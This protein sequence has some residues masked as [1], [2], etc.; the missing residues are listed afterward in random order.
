MPLD[1]YIT[2]GRSG[3]R[4]S[5]L[6]LGAMTFGEEWGWGST[7]ED[8]A[9]ILDAYF[10][11]GGNFIDT[12]NAYTKGHSE[13]IIG[14]H[15]GKNPAKRDRAVIA[16]KFY[17]NLY[18]GD[19][20][21]GGANRKSI[22]GACEQS[23]RCLQTDYIDLY[24]MHAWD[25]NTPIVETM[26][27]LDDLVSSGKVRYVGFSDIPAW[28]CA[29][30]QTTATLRGWNTLVAL[31][32]EYSLL[33]RSVEGELVPMA[34]EMGLG[35]TP[36][37]PLKGGALSGKFKRDGK[38]KAGRGER[39]TAVLNE[40]TFALLD[41]MESISKELGTTV[42]RLALAWLRSRPG[43]VSTIIGARTMPQLEDNLG[44]LDVHPTSAM[45]QKL[46]ELTTPTLN[47]PA[48]FLEYVIQASSGGLTI[49]AKTTPVWAMAPASDAERY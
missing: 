37:S 31:Q 38:E 41:A 11:R 12:A 42:S 17:T 23:L 44:S 36:W 16:T 18:P 22:L 30:A 25:A 8:S 6:C 40:K 39:I 47:F 49:N 10:A 20:N 1:H 5:P 48:K 19:P 35:I 26:K 3:L 32:I 43:V 2:L 4:V 46:D 27:A 45:L 15:L 24:W 34:L 14:D 33:E 29:E 13:K 9:T 7:P 21:G 28:K